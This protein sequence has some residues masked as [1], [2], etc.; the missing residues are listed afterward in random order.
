MKA[1]LM[2]QWYLNVCFIAHTFTISDYGKSAVVP[3]AH[4][5]SQQIHKKK[6]EA[7]SKC[8]NVTMWPTE[9]L[10]GAIKCFPGLHF[11]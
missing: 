11:V 5:N 10:P 6:Q 8:L 9:A 1:Q 2:G 4:S 3:K 7:L